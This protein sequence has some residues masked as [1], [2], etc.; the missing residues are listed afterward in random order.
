MPL[1]RCEAPFHWRRF[2]ADG[3]VVARYWDSPQRLAQGVEIGA[4]LWELLRGNPMECCLVLLD[5]DGRPRE[6]PGPDL[7]RMVNDKVITLYPAK[8]R[9][10]EESNV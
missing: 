10:R 1:E 6:L 8:Y 3:N 9:I 5:G 7:I 2:D 4:E